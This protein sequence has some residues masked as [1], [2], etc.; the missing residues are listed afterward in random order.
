MQGF[1]TEEQLDTFNLP[2]YMRSIEDVKEAIASCGSLFGVLTTKLHTF[3]TA[4]H[5][6]YETVISEPK[7]LSRNM[8]FVYK[9]VLNGLVEAHVGKEA[10]ELIWQRYLELLEK[11]VKMGK[12]T[13]A[14][15]IVALIRK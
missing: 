1:I 2:F 5:D 6:A 15:C 3:D 10:A 7:D 9:A 14:V 4:P 12:P 8:G 13:H 11:R